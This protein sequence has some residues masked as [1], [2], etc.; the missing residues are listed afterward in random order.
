[1]INYSNLILKFRLHVCA[2]QKVVEHKFSKLTLDLINSE[3][4]KTEFGDIEI[5]SHK[6]ALFI[7]KRLAREMADELS[8]TINF[9]NEFNKDGEN[10]VMLAIKHDYSSMLEILLPYA[11]LNESINMVKLNEFIKIQV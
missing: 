10:P 6:L 4:N 5:P 3:L 11:K 8:F 2:S 9:V 7:L 1:M